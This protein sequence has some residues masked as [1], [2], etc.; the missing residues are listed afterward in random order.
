[1]NIASHASSSSI[2]FGELQ[3][4]MFLHVQMPPLLKWY[5]M[6]LSTHDEGLDSAGALSFW[7]EEYWDHG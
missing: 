3:V 2:K 6:C 5:Y 1:M 7:L 4:Q